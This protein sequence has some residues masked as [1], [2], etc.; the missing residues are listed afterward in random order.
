MNAAVA[1]PVGNPPLLGNLYILFSTF[2]TILIPLTILVLVIWYF[3]QNYYYQTEK[4]KIMN[5]M[6][7]LLKEKSIIP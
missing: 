1:N 7:A 6:L 4:L 3:K 5:Q 2:L